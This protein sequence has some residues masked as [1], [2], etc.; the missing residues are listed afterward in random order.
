[1]LMATGFWSRR[2]CGVR[3]YVPRAS[4]RHSTL[5]AA[6][7][8]RRG[9]IG[10][11][12][13]SVVFTSLWVLARCSIRNWRKAS[14]WVASFLAPIPAMATLHALLSAIMLLLHGWAS[15]GDE[16]HWLAYIW[17]P[18][19]VLYSFSMTIVILIGMVGRQSSEG[20]REWW[21][22]LGA[23]LA[24]YGVGWMCINVAASYGPKWSAILG[25]SD[26]WKGRS[27]RRRLDRHHA[28][29]PVRRQLVVNR[30]ARA[31]KEPGQ[32]VLEVVARIAPFVF[33]A[34]R[35]GGRLNRF[36]P[37]HHRPFRSDVEQR[38][39]TC[40]RGTGRCCPVA[41]VT[42]RWAILGACIA[43][44]TLLAARVDINEFSLNAFYRSRLVRCYLGA[45]RFHAGERHPQNFTGF[46]DERRLEA[47]R[48]RADRQVQPAGP[49]H[50]VNCALNLGGS[51]DL[52]LHTRHSATFTLTPLQCG[53]RYASRDRSGNNEELGYIP[54]DIFGGQDGQP[55]LGQAIS[56]S[57]AA[58]SPNMGYHTS[59]VVAFL[60]TL[61][62]VRLGWWFPN[63]RKTGT[64]NP[65]PWF[66]LRYLFTELFGGA[67]DKSKYLAISDG[68]HFENLAAYEL[69]KRQCRL[70]IISDAECDPQT[71]NS[72]VSEP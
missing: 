54:T 57:G 33:I 40:N 63:P 66:S 69:V 38:Q 46:D 27:L 68:G 23:W 48:T 59:H 37:R 50:I 28:G 13:L 71:C 49:L 8:K 52:A 9:N 7:S 3:A 42:S 20:V 29:R 4:S 14:G 11:F 32:Q 30:K 72:R 39:R 31:T 45:T 6:F 43:A 70:I 34:G 2:S 26:T 65:S 18:P 61:F 25:N 67:D 19:M 21:S 58:A 47:R 36:A 22:R 62:N 1:M 17:G 5:S 35:A 60:L 55:T 12:P 56:V 44:V 15:R 16:G 24:I 64:Q 53:S 51:S 10:R 41:N